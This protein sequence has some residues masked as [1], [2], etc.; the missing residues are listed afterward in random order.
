[1]NL[2]EEC[3]EAKKYSCLTHRTNIINKWAQL[4]GKKFQEMAIHIT[5]DVGTAIDAFGCNVKK[6]SVLSIDAPAK[7]IWSGL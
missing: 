4:Y 3:I 7:T 6:N 5:P 2:I 1:M